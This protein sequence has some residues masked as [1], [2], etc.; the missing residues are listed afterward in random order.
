M[1]L[2]VLFAILATVALLAVG[3]VVAL[4]R[5]KRASVGEI[6]LIGEIAH[7]DAELDPEGTVIVRGELWRARSNTGASIPSN[8][9]VRVVG[10]HDLL[11][12]V[13]VAL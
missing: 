9:R 3:V 8:A 11:L 4:Y 7:V 10:L 12:L 1:K 6:R 5:H 13:E 2:F